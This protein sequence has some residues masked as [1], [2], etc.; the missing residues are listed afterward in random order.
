MKYPALFVAVLITTLGLAV[1]AIAGPYE[2][3]H[4]AYLRDD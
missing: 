3:E 2:D 4:A 1:P